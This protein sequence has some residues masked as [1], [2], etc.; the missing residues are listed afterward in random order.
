MRRFR[1]ATWLQNNAF[2]GWTGVVIAA[3][4]L[5]VTVVATVVALRPSPS[6]ERSGRPLSTE[7]PG[8]D[9]VGAEP[10]QPSSAPPS[11]VIEVRFHG[12]IRLS[13]RFKHFD[14]DAS[15]IVPSDRGNTYVDLVAGW[16]WGAKLS[17]WSSPGEPSREDCLD[18]LTNYPVG[19][20]DIEHD[21]ITCALSDD[22]RPTRLKTIDTN[23]GLGSTHWE[24][25][26]TVWDE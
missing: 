25:E 2:I 5:A 9:V 12:T 15:P 4:S 8:A 20:V 16:L 21:S 22:G 14:L 10:E 19:R 3:A 23:F 13:S 18:R 1:L 7:A 24:V 17:E 26:I 6:S 11:R